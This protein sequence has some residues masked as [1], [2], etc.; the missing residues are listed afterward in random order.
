MNLPALPSDGR[1]PKVVTK[2][3]TFETL[4][5]IGISKIQ[6]SRCQALAAKSEEELLAARA[7]ARLA[8]M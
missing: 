8:A 2:V 6:S 3:T 1:Q 7:R 4:G 5:K